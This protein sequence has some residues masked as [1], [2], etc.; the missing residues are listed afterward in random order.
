M[1]TVD[2][3][4]EWLGHVQPVGLVVAPIVLARYGLTPEIQTRAETETARAFISPKPEDGKAKAAD[5]RALK[6]P[7]AFFRGVLGWRAAQ[8][9]G[10]PG[11][12]A[13]DESLFLKVEESETEIAPDWAV[14]APEGGW[15]ILVRI[16]GA[17]VSPDERGALAGWEAT[18]HQR[19]ER[20][21]REKQTA[22]GV[23]ATDDDLRVVYAPRGETSGWMTFPIRSLAEVGGRPML[24]GLKLLLSSFR[25][26]NDAPERR[27]PALLKASREAQ[28]EVST[29]LAGQVLG[30]LHEFLRG[31]HAA[32][33]ER[34][35]A[36]AQRNPEHLYDGLL[37]VLLR[38]VF[39][40]YAEDR[41]LIPSRT[42]AEARAFYGQGYGVRALYGQLLDDRA[43]HPDTM[44]ERRGAWG[45]L[46]AL[47]SLVHHGD[48]TGRWVRGRGGRLFDPSVYPFLQGRET[49][50]DAPAPAPVSDGCVLR[51]LDALITVNGEKLSYRTL[52]VEQIGSVYET[53]MGFAVETRAGPAVAIK[54]G[55]NDRTPV[56]VDLAALAAV[57]G[58][59]RQKFLKEEAGRNALSDKLAKAL[60]T[61]KGTAEA[62]EAL[63]PIIDERG[64]PGGQVSAPGTPLLQP[65]D[66]R[67]RT[68]SHYT[69]RSLTQPIVQH[70]LEPAFE[71]IG[72]DAKPDEVLALKICDPAM[73]SGAFLVEACRALG[74]RLVAAW[75]RWPETR[76]KIPNGEDEPLHARRL[77]AQRCLYGVDKNPRA[78]E[79]AKLS[80]RLATLARDHEFT[81][82][83]HAL[84]CGDSLVGLSQAQIAAVDWD[85]RKP[86]L[87]LFQQFVA[88]IVEE[89]LRG[90]R[91]IQEAPDDTMRAIQEARFHRV[92]DCVQPAR[93]LG[94]ATLAAFFSE[95][96]P[97]PREKRR[98]EVESLVSGCLNDAA[99]AKL[100]AIAAA[101]REGEQPIPPFHWRLEFPEVF[102]PENPGF[103]AII[104]NPPFAG[105][106][107]IIASHRAHYLPWLQTLHEG[108]HGNADLVAHF[109]RRAF[110]LLRRGGVFGLIATNTI[111][112][113]DT[114]ISGL[115][116]ITAD[117]GAIVRA[118]RRLKWPGEAAV[119]VSVV[120]VVKGDAV[121]PI[122]D[123]CQV[124]RISAYL[125]EGDLDASPQTLVANSGKAFV[126]SYLLG[127]GFTFDD[128]AAAKGEAETLETMRA[129]IAKNP[130]NAGRIFP[131]VGG[132]EVNTSPTHAH[133]RYVINFA[134]FPLRRE[135][136]A[137]TFM[138][139]SLPKGKASLSEG[140]VPA[141]YPNPVAADWPDLLEIV[142]RRVRPDREIQNRETRRNRWWQYAEKSPR[143]YSAIVQLDHVFV[144]GAAAVMYHMFSRIPANT[145]FSHKLIVLA[146][147]RHSFFACLQGRCHELRSKFFGTTFGSIDALT[148][149]PTAVF[150]TFPFPE[151]FESIAALEVV[152]EAY[153]SFRSQLMT[154][155]NEGLTKT[156]N[157]FHARDE[158]AADIVHLRA[159][160]ADM[161]A[162]VL[163]A[164]GWDD[165][166][167]RA[168]PEFI[169][170]DADQGKA[171]K[172][173]IDWPAEFKDEVLSRLLAVNAERAAAERAAG[174][175]T[176]LI[177]DEGAAND[178]AEEV[179]AL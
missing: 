130:R 145:I 48:R 16:E 110:G 165:L 167:D 55:K 74:E 109:F 58:T 97:R 66:E 73:G 62:L 81:F 112:Q 80:L 34:I 88:K 142:E 85:E 61:A 18:P 44:D 100:T 43:H 157:R 117:G 171:P 83:N 63:R 119:V 134:D 115:T 42:D 136:M 126:G 53:V 116:E 28:A 166:A 140:I 127:V 149:N 57:A 33:R 143:L 124:R 153:L 155:R 95:A 131:Y 137:K 22:I 94:D 98:Q 107:T 121:S 96:K 2:P 99:W 67:R 64:S 35:E 129:L 90:R 13:L 46:L 52:D 14:A 23:L 69:P 25:L 7:W 178:E 162:A 84:K 91:E 17:G 49:A 152:G 11:G 3:N 6:D 147:D 102:A 133:H 141:D 24:G 70:A 139:I 56:F 176:V 79:L 163:R 151:K 103:D 36:L 144:T 154:A 41:D 78:V 21:L 120:H 170:Q 29:R 87:P 177:D 164:Y 160:H 38:L 77:V 108:A 75:R 20:L 173:R 39:L 156:Y 125:V 19:F 159:L 169:E 148:Y 123:D 138:A 32:D 132:E 4:D 86:G 175:A 31:L 71:R 158:N 65:T 146:C 89:A 105:K 172:T 118:R 114:R 92:D 45:R 179:D 54:A 150:R 161:D 174:I 106:N 128:V 113:G 26:H 135:G 72:P 82:A 122:L 111:G 1:P 168:A 51:I 27:L 30:A 50:G 59:E 15:Q 40:L 9:D 60:A 101:L 5:Q 93:I 68:G 12:P 8:V 104:G 76:P 10:A 47:F 37:A